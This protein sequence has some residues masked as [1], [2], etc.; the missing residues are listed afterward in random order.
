MK[1][2]NMF[3]EFQYVNFFG[4]SYNI[5][6]NS[7]V[8][9]SN[10][11][12]AEIYL[13]NIISS[14]EENGRK[15]NIRF[16]NDITEVVK[17][18]AG[19]H[20]CE[21]LESYGIE[22]Y[23]NEIVLSSP[24][25][26]GL[27][28]AVSTLWQLINA[29]KISVGVI[30][31]YPD[32][33]VRGYRVYTPG[34]NS[35]NAFKKMV[36]M[37]VFYKYNFIIIEVGGA[38]EYKKHPEINKKWVEFCAE[39]NKSPYEARRIQKE[40]FPWAKNSIHADNGG[41]GFISQTEMREIIAYCHE[42]E[43]AVIPEVPSLSHSDYIVMAHPE[44]NE[45]KEDTY[46]D[47]YCPSNPESYEILFEIIDEVIDVFNPTYMNIGHDELYTVAICDKCKGKTPAD[48]YV[49]DIVKINNYLKA[50]GIA[51][52]M[53]SDKLYGNLY[54]EYDGV[55]IPEGGT[56]NPEKG[57]PRLAECAGKIPK[58]I[59]LLQWYWNFCTEEMEKEVCDMGYKMIYGNFIAIELD[60]YRKRSALTEGGFVSNWGS[61][62]EEYMQRNGQN[63][64][65]VSSA[66]IW[67][68]NR[69]DNSLKGEL[70]DKV[71][72]ELYC[73]YI[74]SL[75]CDYIELFH[76]TDYFREYNVF[77]DGYYIVPEEW[78]IGWHEVTYKDGTKAKFPVVYGYNIRNSTCE[79]PKEYKSAEAIG[80][81]YVEILG[82]TY[83]EIIDG[84]VFYKTAYK[85]PYP[86]KEIESIKYTPENEVL[87]D[88]IYD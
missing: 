59:T 19:K 50:K 26:R 43:L 41:G 58:D 75:G 7:I 31:D 67:W 24:S 28:Y 34:R 30:F 4:D 63:Y 45:R 44:L 53:W 14:L 70:L 22:I 48:I 6:S 15:I 61:V 32:K 46:P 55:L 51:T 38:M 60:N 16:E 9:D 76:T 10:A 1:I 3:F 79:M 5:S 2:E 80:S 8:C 12:Y 21:N 37:L 62:E 40:T 73:K 78:I 56:G 42:R 54:V 36:D 29:N 71:K 33:K 11:G 25:K 66:F 52:L 84:K 83:P 23:D 57:I 82:A 18:S 49:E 13:K 87:V 47:T 35:I 39:V 81:E 74:K 88:L 68:S 20:Y 65:L 64:A 17:K 77:Y 27:I 72:A 69:Y 86:K 85:N